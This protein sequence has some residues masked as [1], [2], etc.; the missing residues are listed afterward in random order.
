MHWVIYKCHLQRLLPQSNPAEEEV[1]AATHGGG[2]GTVHCQNGRRAGG[3][4][5]STTGSGASS[6]REGSRLWAKRKVNIAQVTRTPAVVLNRH[7]VAVSQKQTERQPQKP[8][9]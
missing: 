3:A 7:T 9:S 8:D 2:G 4:G 6:Q 5:M 1:M